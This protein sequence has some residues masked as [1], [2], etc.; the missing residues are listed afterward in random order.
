MKKTFFNLAKQ[1]LENKN[2]STMLQKPININHLSNIL[3]LV[4][5]EKQHLITQTVFKQSIEEVKQ[6][7]VKGQEFLNNKQN[8]NPISSIESFNKASQLTNNII[9]TYGINS[10]HLE[11]KIILSEAYSGYANVLYKFKTKEVETIKEMI[12]KSLE[13]NPNNEKAKSIDFD[14]RLY[15]VVP[16]LSRT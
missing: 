3:S 10:L 8:R 11:D 16:N 6:D 14:L 9:E 4:S 5:I 13:L 2:Y 1:S 15:D 12:Q 7:I